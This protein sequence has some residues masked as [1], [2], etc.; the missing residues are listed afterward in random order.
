[1]AML[2]DLVELVIGVDTHK[3]THTAAVVAATTGAV[4]SQATVTATPAGY[5]Q[6][7]ALANRHSGRRVWAV[8]GTGGYGA[9][10]T[11]FL[12]GHAEQVVELDR[13]KRAARRHGAKSD[14]LDATRAAREA[15]GRDQLAQ[16]RAAGQRAALSVRLTARRSAVQ[17]TTD[18]Q[19]Q[20]HA[21]VVAAP[22]PLRGRL[23]GLT[24]PRLVS[25][26]GRFRQRT[27]GDLEV[28][29]SAASLRAL[30]RRIQLLDQEIAEHTRAITA[31]V[32]S[33]RPELLT[34]TGVGPIV[35]AIVLCAWSHA[36]RCR[37]DAAF[38]M[39]G[40]A[41]PIPASSGQ[42]VRVRL[43]RSGDR[44][45]NQALHVI[46]LTRLRYD[47]ATRAYAQRRRAEGK[48]NREIKRCLVRYV[49]RQLYRLLEAN[50][51]FDPT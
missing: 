47:P 3:Q 10:L 12:H 4:I 34:R 27:D 2:A 14:P 25:T 43:N 38:A 39:L 9:G 28:A 5:R 45:L 21:L 22:D 20:L 40:G 44:Q 36:G 6:L 11:R 16:P 32:R 7:L 13:P 37:S 15:L 26:C 18:A 51:G 29:A 19:R 1:M 41:A 49:A 33:W 23:R 50:P 30:A 35:A 46:V 42:T 24:T 48:T 8:E 31:L 17:A